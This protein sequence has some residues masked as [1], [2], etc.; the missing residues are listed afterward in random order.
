MR[1]GREQ[2]SK[3]QNKSN[4]VRIRRCQSRSRYNW[5]LI[6]TQNDG[7]KGIALT[8]LVAHI[9]SL[10]IPKGLLLV[11]LCTSLD[12]FLVNLTLT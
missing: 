12:E 8:R 2:F 10:A 9:F 1:G 4:R 6:T 7:Q 5:V 3:L 11:L